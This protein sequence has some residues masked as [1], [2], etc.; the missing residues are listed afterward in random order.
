MKA[1]AA[2]QLYGKKGFGQ[3]FPTRMEIPDPINEKLDVIEGDFPFPRDEHCLQAMYDR[4]M[5]HFIKSILQD[6]I[7]NPGADEGIVNMQIV[8]AAYESA[9]TGQVVEIL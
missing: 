3:V 1:E 9:R 6:K 2:T 7:P 8:D 4:Q 5:D